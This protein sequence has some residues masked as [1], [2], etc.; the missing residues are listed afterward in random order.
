MKDDLDFDSPDFEIDTSQFDENIKNWKK[1][2]KQMA[3]RGKEFQEGIQK[4]IAQGSIM[5]AQL[6]E[7]KWKLVVV[8][9]IIL[10]FYIVTRVF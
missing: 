7:D 9:V 1:N 10:L 8:G 3:K 6:E 2:E 5:M 4:G